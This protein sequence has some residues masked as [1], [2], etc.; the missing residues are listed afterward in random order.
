MPTS[1]E[2]F[3]PSAFPPV[4]DE[5]PPV[6]LLREQAELLS[7]KTG[8][9]VEGVITTTVLEDMVYHSLYMR[10]Q[11]LGDYMYKIV[12]LAHPVTNA[13][14]NPFPLDAVVSGGSGLPRKIDD[15]GEFKKWLRSAL[16]SNGV[17]ATVSFLIKQSELASSV[18]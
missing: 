5:S 7:G 17:L 11:A 14:D 6:A 4:Q 8:N 15:M 13:S 9:H 2:D 1:H 16:T 3:W 10:A 12:S 18:S